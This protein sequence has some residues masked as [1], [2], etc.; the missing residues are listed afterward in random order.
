MGRVA[1]LITSHRWLKEWGVSLSSEKR[2]R[3]V[4][5]RIIGDNL[6]AEA[7]PFSFPLKKGGEE[8]RA[9]AL[10]FVPE[11]LDK[12]VDLLEDNDRY[13]LRTSTGFFTNMQLDSLG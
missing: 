13:K 9:A 8:I 1:L 5:K 6:E 3:V 12:V 4:A 7:V 10:C 2:Q 11:L